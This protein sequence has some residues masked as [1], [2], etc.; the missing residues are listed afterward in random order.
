MI[1]TGHNC[2]SIDSALSETKETGGE[3]KEG[4]KLIDGVRDEER[5]RGR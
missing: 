4:D 2:H 3:G 5:Q 1:Y